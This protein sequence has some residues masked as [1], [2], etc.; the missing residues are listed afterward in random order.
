MLIVSPPG[1]GHFLKAAAV[2]GALARR[3]HNVTVCTT[4][5]DDFDREKFA[6]EAGMHFISAGRDPYTYS[7]FLKIHSLFDQSCNVWIRNNSLF[8]HNGETSS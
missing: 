6:A 4:E 2:G 5:R 3:G 1:H 8:F 7:E